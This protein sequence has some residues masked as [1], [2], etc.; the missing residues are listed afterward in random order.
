MDRQNGKIYAIF[1]PDRH[2]IQEQAR[3]YL[4]ITLPTPISVPC[5]QF[6]TVLMGTTPP[7]VESIRVHRT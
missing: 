6:Q 3:L 7:I 5:M 4:F 1:P 2:L